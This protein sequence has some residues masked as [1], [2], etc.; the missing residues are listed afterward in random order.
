MSR[1]TWL[2]A[3]L[4]LLGGL[5]ATSYLQETSAPTGPDPT[6]ALIAN[7]GG[8]V[9]RLQ[10]Q[11]KEAHRQLARLDENEQRSLELAARLR[12][13]EAE[14]LHAR[15]R[16]QRQREHLGRLESST[17]EA[18]AQAV[19]LRIH[20]FAR[21]LDAEWKG[22]RGRVDEIS[23]LATRHE[24][25]LRELSRNLSRD[26]DRMWSELLGPTVQL[27]GTATVGSGVLLP[28]IPL[29]DG[30]H[31]TYLLTAWHVVRDIQSNPKNPVEPVPVYVYLRDGGKLDQTARLL[32]HDAAL[33][34]ALLV[35]ESDAAFE[36]GARLATREALDQIA[37]FGSVYAV[38]CPL[39]NDPIPTFGE[40][41]DLRHQIDGEPYW[42]ISAP[43]Y[44]GNSGGGI[45]DAATHEL[46]GIFSKIYTHGALRPTVVP[47]MGL[48]TPLARIYDWLERVG[49]GDLVPRSRPG[50]EHLSAASSETP[51]SRPVA[52]PAAIASKSDGE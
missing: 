9:L 47:H 40:V 38:G 16:L 35:M 42:M 26:T 3:T 24:G 5:S 27:S 51:S 17:R 15:Q 2:L 34:A 28:S 32:V 8:E 41:A 18:A 31:R 22:L 21:E 23:G 12:R 43:T 52:R 50:V 13:L 20:G 36:H 1:S 10:G 29:E 48:V 11:L 49:H 39:G 46:I 33:D 4:G 45:F 37:I 44:I 30:R 19:D 6:L 14:L 7:V 25:T